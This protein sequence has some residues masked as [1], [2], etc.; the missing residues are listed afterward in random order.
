M[1]YIL[2]LV[3]SIY[4][5]RAWIE[6]YI[7]ATIGAFVLFIGVAIF[8]AI[9]AKDDKRGLRAEKIVSELLKVFHRRT[10]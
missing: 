7:A 5:A 6:V 8:V 9:F 3:A 2:Y 1:L 10:R 4:D